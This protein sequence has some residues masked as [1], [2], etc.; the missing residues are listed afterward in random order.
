[1]PGMS[2][3]PAKIDVFAIYCVAE[4]HLFARARPVFDRKSK[5]NTHLSREAG[6]NGYSEYCVSWDDSALPQ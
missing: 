3:K 1:M 6:L 4:N 5:K 2:T